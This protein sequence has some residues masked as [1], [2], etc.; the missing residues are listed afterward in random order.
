MEKEEENAKDK[1]EKLKNEI[2][3]R[4][5]DADSKANKILKLSDDKIFEISIGKRIVA[6]E[7]DANGKIPVF[8]ANVFEPFG[9]VNKVLIED[10]TV[11]S[12]LW[13]IDGDWMVNFL[14]A[15]K[16]FYPTDHCG[17]LRVTGDE[18]L[19]K[20]LVWL[21][22][23]EGITFGFSRVL[24]ASI[25]RIKGLNVNVPPLPEQQKFVTETEKF[26]SRILEYQKI[27]ASIAMRKTDIIKQFL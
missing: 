21:L 1:V 7:L 3:Q 2:E 9:Y 27:I 25:D 15:N 22:N 4:F 6:D 23:K 11:P 5:N 13:G 10:F 14:P 18:I 16:P 8:S 17:I 19:A 26:E 20:Y 24:R 12:I